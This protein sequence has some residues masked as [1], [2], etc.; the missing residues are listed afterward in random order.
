MGLV[1]NFRMDTQP[2]SVTLRHGD[3][4]LDSCLRKLKGSITT[5]FGWLHWNQP[6]VFG[7]MKCSR[8]SCGLGIRKSQREVVLS[9]GQG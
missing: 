5:G 8:L 9:P 7:N 2:M 6:T 3:A 4:V 1:G